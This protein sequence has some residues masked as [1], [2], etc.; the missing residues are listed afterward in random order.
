MYGN[1]V[2]KVYV[3]PKKIT[4]IKRICWRKTSKKQ[5]N[6]YINHYIKKPRKEMRQLRRIGVKY[7][8]YRVEYE[9]ASNYRNV[10]FSRT[11]GPYRCRY[12]NKQ[13]SKDKVFIDHIIP[14]AKAQKTLSAKLALKLYGCSNV[15]DIRNLAPACNTCNLKK[16]DKT[17]LWVLRG[18]L[19]KYKLYWIFLIFL[20]F[21]CICFTVI[22]LVWIFRQIISFCA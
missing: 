20:K 14:I 10:F 16:S 18:W 7:I 13:L 19:G 2:L 5:K 3:Q 15:N 9:R 22:G 4:K 21:L 6:C 1:W 12:C 11:K 8:C 17:G